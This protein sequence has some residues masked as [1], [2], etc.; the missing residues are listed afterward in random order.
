VFV[1]GHALVAQTPEAFGYDADG[2]LTNDGKWSLTWDGENRL[3]ALQS[4]STIPDAAKRRMEYAYDEQ[5]RRIYAKIMEWNTNSTS[6]SLI[7]E[8]RYWYDGWN[9]IG[10]ADR[11]TSLV[12]DFIWGFD[13]SGTM[14]GAGGVGGLL[15]LDDSQGASYFYE[16]DGNGNVLG[17]IN[18]KDGTTAAQYDYDPYLTPNSDCAHR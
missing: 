7:T 16:Y 5:G 3:V 17:L 6:Y 14:Q 4:L 12:Q 13:L 2:N 9:I 15:I 10:R 8:E 1:N 11:A 18:A